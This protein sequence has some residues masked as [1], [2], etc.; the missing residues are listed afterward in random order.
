MLYY[1]VNVKI[2]KKRVRA[3]L[4]KDIA[5]HQGLDSEHAAFWEAMTVVCMYLYTHKHYI[6]HT[7][8]HTHTHTHTHV[9]GHAQ[10]KAVQL[11]IQ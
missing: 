11:N 6:T 1:A 7:N 5:V 8:T 4:Q 3:E 10:G 9:A 2:E